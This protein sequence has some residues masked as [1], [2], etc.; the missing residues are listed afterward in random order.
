MLIIKWAQLRNREDVIKIG[1][2]NYIAAAVLI[3]PHFFGQQF[4]EISPG[5]M[6]TGGSMG[7]IYFVAFFFAI[8]SIKVVG[9]SSTTVVSVLSFR[10]ASSRCGKP[11]AIQATGCCRPARR[12]AAGES[13]VE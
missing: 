8:Y 4:S 7:A 12:A 11:A 1:A 9:A 3:A 2:I 5:A 6:W 13:R 10:H